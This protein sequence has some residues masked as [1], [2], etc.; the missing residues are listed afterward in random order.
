MKKLVLICFILLLGF[1]LFSTNSAESADSETQLHSADMPSAIECIIV[2]GAYQ[3]TGAIT[4]KNTQYGFEFKLPSSW[5]GYSIITDKW[6]GTPIGGETPAE[7]GPLI[8]IRHPLWTQ[9]N[10]R[11][12]IPIMVFTIAQW[13]ALQSEKF[14]IGA[15]PIGPSELGRNSLYVFALPARYNYA[16]LTGFEAVEK[17]ISGKPLRPIEVSGGLAQ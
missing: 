16:F 17:I 12:D 4:Y 10:P 7:T 13:N 8:S 5:K 3:Q 9:E 6:E 11:Q 15:A 1:L 14:H 2:K